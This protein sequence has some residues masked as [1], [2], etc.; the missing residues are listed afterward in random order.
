MPK[1][2]GTISKLRE[3]LR[4][5]NAGYW[6]VPQW[7]RASVM[8]WQTYRLTEDDLRHYFSD[9][10]ANIAVALHKSAYMDVECDSEEAEERLRLSVSDEELRTPTW[11]SRRGLHR[12]YLKPSVGET[13]AK[14]TVEG[15]E[16]RGL[17]EGGALSTVPPS[18]HP[19]SGTRYEWV[20][21]LSVWEIEPLPLPNALVALLEKA[22]K[23]QRGQAST[24]PDAIVEGGNRN[25]ELFRL[26]CR[27]VASN[28]TGPVADLLHGA[29]KRRCNPALDDKE[30]DKIIASVLKTVERSKTDILPIPC[31]SWDKVVK[32]WQSALEWRDD[33]SEVLA[34]AFAV[35]ASTSQT[36]DQQL[37]LQVVGR[38]GCLHGYTPIYDPTDNSTVTVEDRWKKGKP[39]FVYTNKRGQ[40]SISQ[41][42]PPRR[43]DP[44]P[45][46]LVT[47]ESGRQI[48]VTAGHRFWDGSSYVSLSGL[49]ESD[50]CRLPSIEEFDLSVRMQDALRLMQITGDSQ[51]GC[52]FCSCFYGEL[53]RCGEDTDLETSPSP[54]GVQVHS[55][56]ERAGD[57]D[58]R[59]EHTHAASFYHRANKGYH[60]HFSVEGVY[61]PLLIGGNEKQ[62]WRCDRVDERTPFGR[63]RIDTTGQFHELLP[64]REVWD[65]NPLVHFASSSEPRRTRI[66]R[67]AWQS[68]GL[69]DPLGSAEVSAPHEQETV[70]S[71]ALGCESSPRPAPNT[72]V[73][74][75]DQPASPVRHLLECVPTRIEFWPLEFESGT[76]QSSHPC[77]ASVKTLEISLGNE[78]IVRNTDAIVNVEYVG[79]DHY[80]DFCVPETN[81]YWAVGMF[82]HNSA[83]TRICDAMLVSSGCHLLENLT[84]FVSGKNDGTDKDYSLLSRINH[85]CLITPEM[86][87]MMNAPNF[88][89]L[90]SQTR[91]IFDGS[92]SS[93]YKNRDEE[94]RH[95]GLRTPWIGA[96]TPAILEKPQAHLGDRFLK[97]YMEEPSDDTQR[98]ILRKA[99]MTSWSAAG[100]ESNCSPDSIL[101]P[102]LKLAYQ[103]TG[104]YIDWLRANITRR[105]Q[106]QSAVNKDRVIDRCSVL[107]DFTAYMRSHPPQKTSNF[108]PEYEAT[109]ELPARLQYQFVRLAR[110]LAVV[111]GRDSVD[112]DVLRIVRRVA[113]DTSRGMVL[114]ICKFLAMPQHAQ[115][116]CSVS[117]LGIRLMQTDERIARWL[118]H[119]RRVGVADWRNENEATRWL[120]TPRMARLYAEVRD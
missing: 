39:F 4:L 66:R 14:V 50:A 61:Q 44:E 59:Q 116:G 68:F 112:E 46:Y 56:F 36:G 7:G 71:S 41:A 55:R 48:T 15:I 63:D 65:V 49:L 13:R 30:V 113:M 100:I 110:C 103:T 90:M 96:G 69:T 82:H 117:Y 34:V 19:D 111:L 108:E 42:L 94:L 25:E 86:D 109:K 21:G 40:I 24:E 3:A 67:H 62:S 6:V 77:Y 35:A 52:R 53:L 106:Q 80:Y 99:G 83:K 12:L 88:G 81:N 32:S 74:Q 37:F 58:S 120:L 79:K 84:G 16:F 87:V 98:R 28:G 104:G 91:R 115:N 70:F 76:T 54:D 102:E 1:I 119:M 51:Y 23:R 101:T 95:V 85:K 47:F 118:A 18:V 31:D 93:S 105:L 2:T 20:D 26:G 60:S 97:V 8:D 10:R 92:M 22:P 57:L 45:M 78:C 43:Y 73:G 64:Q 27:I 107:A 114:S 29:N 5:H 89:V 11:R 75:L 38:A 17:G 9:E 33:M 72:S